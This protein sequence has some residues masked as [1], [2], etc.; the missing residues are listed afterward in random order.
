MDVYANS[1]EGPRMEKMSFIGHYALMAN[2]EQLILQ[3]ALKYNF[4]SLYLHDLPVEFVP[5]LWIPFPE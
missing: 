2:W 4:L 1:K 3:V 5:D